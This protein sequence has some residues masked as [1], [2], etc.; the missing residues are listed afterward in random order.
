MTWQLNDYELFDL[1]SWIFLINIP[2]IEFLVGL[3]LFTKK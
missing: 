3:I 1:F 2:L